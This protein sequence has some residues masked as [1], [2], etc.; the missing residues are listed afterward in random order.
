ML[1]AIQS[2]LISVQLST[3]ISFSHSSLNLTSR[4]STGIARITGFGM[5]IFLGKKNEA[6]KSSEKKP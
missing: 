5:E 1:G 4:G 2:W 3:F 6:L